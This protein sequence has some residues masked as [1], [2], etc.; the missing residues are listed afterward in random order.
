VKSYRKLEQERILY[1][2]EYKRTIEEENSKYGKLHSKERWAVLD[3][4]YLLLGLLG[5]GGYSEV[6]K[7]YIVYKIIGL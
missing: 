5:K 2:L 4:R 1:Q 7:V 3:Q 6:Y